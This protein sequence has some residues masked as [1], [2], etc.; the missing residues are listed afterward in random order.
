MRRFAIAALLALPVVL[1]G[2]AVL[3]QD[4]V[5]LCANPTLILSDRIAEH[6]DHGEPGVSVGDRRVGRMTMRTEAGEEAG[7]MF[8]HSHMLREPADAHA[9]LIT[10]QNIFVTD[11]GTI[12]TMYVQETPDQNYADAEHRPHALDLAVIG[13]TGA[14]AAARGQITVV[15]RAATATFA[16]VCP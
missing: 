5:D 7:T 13:G 14:Y 16:L 2:N 11:R 10:G 3:A 4:G 15:S 12:F 6:I 9:H 1:P 8:F